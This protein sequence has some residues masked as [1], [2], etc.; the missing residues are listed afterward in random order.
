M[1]VSPCQFSILWTILVFKRNPLKRFS[2]EHRPYNF[3]G[4]LFMGQGS[5]SP[6]PLFLQ[7]Q[8]KL[9]YMIKSIIQ[10]LFEV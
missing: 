8:L 7:E 6:I 5:L 1:F 3:Q 10:M 2:D 9:N 4:A